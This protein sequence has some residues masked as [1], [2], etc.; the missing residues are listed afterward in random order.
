MVL[1]DELDVHMED[2]ESDKM[3]GFCLEKLNGC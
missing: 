2:D 1:S 3:I